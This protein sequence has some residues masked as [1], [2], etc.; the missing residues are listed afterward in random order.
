MAGL[1]SLFL[2]KKHGLRDHS[3]KRKSRSRTKKSADIPKEGNSLR[4]IPAAH[5]AFEGGLISKQC[6]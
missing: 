4:S 1:R 2:H 3:S 6:V 5:R